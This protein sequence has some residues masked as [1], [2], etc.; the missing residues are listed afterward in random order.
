MRFIPLKEPS[1]SHLR[2]P[3]DLHDSLVQ[4]DGI[5]PT[6]P[7][8]KAGVLPLNYACGWFYGKRKTENGQV[9]YAFSGKTEK[10]YRERF[11]NTRGCSFRNIFDTIVSS[12]GVLRMIKRNKTVNGMQKRTCSVVHRKPFG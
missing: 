11:G 5:E 7:A 3:R 10:F 1:S 4:A 12:V 6:I 8:W 2:H 9:F